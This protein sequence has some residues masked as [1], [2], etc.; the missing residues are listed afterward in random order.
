MAYGDKLPDFV[1]YSESVVLLLE[2]PFEIIFIRDSKCRFSI[3]TPPCQLENTLA[4]V[5]ADD[6]DLP[7]TQLFDFQEQHPD[8]VRLFAGS[9]ACAPDTERTVAPGGFDFDQLRNNLVGKCL[10]LE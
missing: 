8:G 2:N 1:V 3:N 9:A 6:L 10:E 4:D 7:A 5:G